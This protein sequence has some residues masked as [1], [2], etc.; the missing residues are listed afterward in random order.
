MRIKS[1]ELAWFRGAADSVSLE[2][3]GKSM[4]VYGENGSGK[5]SFVDAV[6]Y[7]LKNG[8]IEHLRTEYSGTHQVKAILNTHRPDGGNTTLGFKFNDDSYL[9]VDFNPNGS[10]KT[11]GTQGTAIREWEY[12][13]TV[14]RQNEVSEFIHDT[15]GGKYSALLPLFGLHKMEIAA[16]NLRKLAKSVQ[17]EAK[18]NENKIKLKLV[19][20]QRE[21]AF[22]AQ[23]YD[24]IVQTIDNLYTQYCNEAPTASDS[25]SRCNELELAIE[26][27]IKG[28]AVDNQ[29]HFFLRAVAESNLEGNVQAVRA[30][31]VVLAQ[32]LDPQIAEKLEVLRSAGV[33]V[34]NIEGTELVDCPA[35]GQVIAVDE[36]REH[37]RAETERLQEINEIYSTYKAAIGN[38]CK[39]LDSLKSNLHKPDLKSWRDGL[40]KADIVDG[41]EYLRQINPNALRES[42]SEENLSA[43][44]NKLFP[45]INVAERD[46]KD[47]PPDVQKLTADNKL[48]G[49]AKSV[50]AAQELDKEIAQVEGLVALITALEHGI[51]SEIRQQSQ[52]VI[53]SISKDIESMWEILHPGEK[54]DSVR[55]SLPPTTDKAIDVVLQFHGLEQDSPRLTLSEGYRN[56]L[57]LCIFLAMAKQVADS[58]RPLFLD[59]VVVSLDRS[60]RGMIQSLLAKEFSDRQVIILTHDREWYTELRHQFGDN[61]GWALKALLPYETP[62]IGIRW[63]HKTTTFDDARALLQNRPDAAGNDARKIMDQELPQIAEHLKTQLPYLRSE[64]NDRRMAYEFLTRLIADGKKC[65]QKRSENQ[66]SVHMEAIDEL[67]RAKQ[68]ILAWG[69]RASHSFDVV[70]PEATE[71]IDTCEKAIACFKCESCDQPC[72]VWRLDDKESKYVRCRCGEIRWTYGKA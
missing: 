35:C 31:S 63:S 67:A 33:F 40:D 30:A 14:L 68:L 64:K 38:V 36:F 23:K 59:D 29:K 47:A 53:D 16:E 19:E 45:I 1:I 39:S 10:S 37:V 28:H 13:Q 6:E 61:N 69:N 9:K 27:Q 56:S 34:D 54:I 48:L 55:L 70:R 49:V 43:I 20:N 51:R 66:Y 7:V 26:N 2:P 3:N 42:C 50:I 57:G 11:S 60:H 17:N 52:M 12:R 65:F 21:C 18:L 62:E 44:E 15:K 24:D 4:V 41:F 32:S 8:S 71:L 25:L 46:S 58:D 22:G 72:Y 5:S